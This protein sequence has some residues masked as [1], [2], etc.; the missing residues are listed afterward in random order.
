[1]SRNE[2]FEFEIKPRGGFDQQRDISHIVTNVT[3]QRA[4]TRK[5]LANGAETRAFL[6]A[7]VDLTEELFAANSADK[8]PD[9]NDGLRPTMSYLSRDKV[10][11]RARQKYPDLHL[12]ANMLRHRWQSHRDFIA[13]FI[14][15]ALAEEHWSIG[16]AISENSS[17]LLMSGGD[18]PRAVHRVAYEDLKRILELPSYRFQLLAVASAQAD[19]T[20]AEALKRMYANLSEVWTTL[21]GKVFD[22]Y[23]L[24]LRPGTTMDDFNIILQ[25]TAEG[26]GMRLLSGVDEPILDH[27]RKSSLLGTAA[28]ALFAS[29]I[30]PGDG[31]TIEEATARSLELLRTPKA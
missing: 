25:S 5:R 19:S 7:A 20:S 22:H 27:S 16:V 14:S 2:D 17:S 12:G 30:D 31:L 11:Q 29:L 18:F 3:G 8:L 26:L 10:L 23:G 21:Y 4:A 24:S 13:D 6:E 1:M 15:Y 28:M 9:D